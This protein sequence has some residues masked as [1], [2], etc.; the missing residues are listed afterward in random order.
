MTD[1][2]GFV[3]IENLSK[4]KVDVTKLN[5]EKNKQKV[6]GEGK[7]KRENDE[8]ADIIFNRQQLN[9][10]MNWKAKCVCFLF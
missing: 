2:D 7:T 3:C 4:T 9:R 8:V 10:E 1:G 5:K 6:E